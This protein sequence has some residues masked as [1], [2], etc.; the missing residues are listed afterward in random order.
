MWLLEFW[1]LPKPFRRFDRP[2]VKRSRGCGDEGTRGRKDEATRG[3][4]YRHDRAA[5]GLPCVDRAERLGWGQK[6]SRT[7]LG[8]TNQAPPPD[9]KPRFSSQS[10]SQA[11]GTVHDLIKA[12]RT[13]NQ[14]SQSGEPIESRINQSINQ[15][16]ITNRIYRRGSVVEDPHGKME[17]DVGDRG[18]ASVRRSRI[19][20]SKPDSRT[21]EGSV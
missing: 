10:K 11:A 5:S 3:D 18:R 2:I 9:G 8:V 21:G 12:V 6:K 17:T 15:S 20:S 13:T 14:S 1:L 16:P 7:I 4:S 19:K